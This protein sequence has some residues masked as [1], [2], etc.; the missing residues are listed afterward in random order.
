LA[1]AL[2]LDSTLAEA[3]HLLAGGKFWY[4]WDWE[5]AEAA[6]RRVIELNPNYPEGR[7]AYALFLSIMKRPNEALEQSER[8]MELDPFLDVIQHFHAQVLYLAR[9][10]DDAMAQSQWVLRTTPH[11]PGAL[12]VLSNVYHAKGMYEEEVAVTRSVYTVTGFSEAEQAL[13][14]GYAEGDYQAAA[15]PGR[16][17]GG[18]TEREAGQSR[19]N[20]VVVFQ[21]GTDQ[22]GPRL[23]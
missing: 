5:G 22:P 13:A 17:V 19:G 16:F 7:S 1:R 2:E 3:Q 18:A 11:H 15:P 10:Y 12:N 8:A 6:F 20:R 21:C 14:L 23:A 4:E 9:R